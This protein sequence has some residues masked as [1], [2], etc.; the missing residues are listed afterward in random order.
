MNNEMKGFLSIFIANDSLRDRVFMI[1]NSKGNFQNMRQIPFMTQIQVSV[2]DN[3]LRFSLINGPEESIV[4]SFP[5][6]EPK[7]RR[8][9]R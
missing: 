9:G 1:T 6:N 4:I 8:V 3:V 7:N 5:K 2:Q